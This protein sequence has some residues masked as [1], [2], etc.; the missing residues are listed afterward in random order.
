MRKIIPLIQG[1]FL[2]ILEAILILTIIVLHPGHAKAGPLCDL[3][4]GP[5]A[6]ARDRAEF[7]RN[8][9]FRRLGRAMQGA[10]NT[11]QQ[12]DPAPAFDEPSPSRG[13]GNQNWIVRDRNGFNHNYRTRCIGPSCVAEPY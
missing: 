9:G 4:K 8:G 6:C 2:L 5:E 7:L 13:G 12:V 1:R 11:L 10:G 3:V